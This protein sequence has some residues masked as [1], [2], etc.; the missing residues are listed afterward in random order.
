MSAVSF[1]AGMGIFRTTGGSFANYL[2]LA[3][4]PVCVDWKLVLAAVLAL[5]IALVM[6][7]VNAVEALP[8]CWSFLRTVLGERSNS[9]SDVSKL[10]RDPDKPF[11]AVLLSLGILH[12]TF[13]LSLA[14]PP[15]LSYT[16]DPTM[17]ENVG[18]VRLSRSA[19]NSPLFPSLVATDPLP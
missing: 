17:L 4:M 15:V 2:T 11:A 6:E 18:S 1:L 8:P 3:S 9:I 19:V 12:C 10:V 13:A 16:T 5:L 7:L 14:G